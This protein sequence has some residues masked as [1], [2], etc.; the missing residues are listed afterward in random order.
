MLTERGVVDNILAAKDDHGAVGGEGWLDKRRGLGEEAG[1]L[2][3]MAGTQLGFKKGTGS[4][5]T[6]NE[7][8][9]LKDAS[10]ARNKAYG[11]AFTP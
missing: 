8:R 3:G 9:D 5:R 2:A 1:S 7:E 4:V 10:V 11:E 6:K